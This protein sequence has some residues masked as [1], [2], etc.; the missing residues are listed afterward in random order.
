[1]VG[2]TGGKRANPTIIRCFERS[3]RIRNSSSLG[4]K[5]GKYCVWAESIYNERE[6][7]EIVTKNSDISAL[8]VSS[9]SLAPY[10][11]SVYL[12]KISK[13]LPVTR[14]GGNIKLYGFFILV[15]HFHH[16]LLL[17]PL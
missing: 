3:R 2:K 17:A 9:A 6:A 1:M 11:K 14:A 4:R 8:P 10:L 13:F 12:F 5:C 15:L 7:G 16:N